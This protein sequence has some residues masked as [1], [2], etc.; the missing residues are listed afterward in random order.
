VL[1]DTKGE[2]KIMGHAHPTSGRE[3]KA[4][5]NGKRPW[6]SGE[7]KKIPSVLKTT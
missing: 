1:I 4:K 5:E 2:K 6:D 7:K 3:E